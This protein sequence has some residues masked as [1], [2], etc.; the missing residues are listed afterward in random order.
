MAVQ[1]G[2]RAPSLQQQYF[3][4]TSTN[5]VDGV[6]FEITT[7][8]ASQPV[9]QALG[10]EELDAEESVNISIGAVLQ[11]GKLDI[12]LDA[13]RI[14]VDDRIVLSE[15]LTQDAVRNFLVSQGFEGIGGARFF[16]NGVDTRTEGVDLVIHYPLE[17]AHAGRFDL[18]LA[19][20]VNSTDVTRV[21]QTAQVAAIN[22]APRVFDRINVLTLEEGT[23]KDKYSVAVNWSL[24]RFG[25]AVRATRYG[26]VL[27]PGTVAAND[28]VLTA[29]TLLDLEVR[30]DVT[31]RVRA[32]I[33]A[34]NILDEYP[35][36]LPPRL[37]L[38]GTQSFSNYSPFG[39]SGR[40]V[41]G[42]VSYRF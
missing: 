14:D 24:Q 32:S 26:D 13:Y 8:P 18:M 20:N 28:L 39:R 3:Q 5:F 4:T 10:A 6:P 1:N 35:D 38:T 21:P 36:K 40:F 41:F 2:F 37:N 7:V 17:T 12:T 9:A 42:K 29:K 11:L 30:L 22:P 25:A 15:N 31:E 34:D 33:G 27:F 16:I 23:P 19:G